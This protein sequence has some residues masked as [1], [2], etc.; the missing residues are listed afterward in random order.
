MPKLQ[1]KTNPTFKARVSIPIPGAKPE[2]VEF[3]FRWRD[4]DELSAWL[5][6]LD[7]KAT[8]A[9]LLEIASGWDLEDAFDSANA[10]TLLRLYIGAWDAIYRKY[11]DELI[12]A[13]AK[14]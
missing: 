7:G 13:R 11:L 1:L 10:A 4:R 2:P 8:D 12:G 5:E 14:N 3:T 6:S 9:A